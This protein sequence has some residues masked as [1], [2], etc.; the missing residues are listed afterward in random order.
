MLGLKDQGVGKVTFVPYAG[1]S[2]GN[3]RYVDMARVRFKEM[4][5]DLDAVTEGDPEERVARAESIVIGG[6]NTVELAQQLHKNRIMDAIRSR[7]KHGGVPYMGWSAGLGVACPTIGTTNDWMIPD[8]STL[9]IQGLDVFPVNIN[10]HYRDPVQITDELREALQAAYT[11]SP[12]LRDELENRG[13]TRIDRINEFMAKAPRQ[14]LGLREG[15]IVRVSGTKAMLEGT[16]GAK[17]FQPGKEPASYKPGDD[18]SF[19]IQAI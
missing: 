6:G 8:Q 9:E 18:L 11:I 19:L 15:G 7:V 10:P 13:E 2:I 4:G 17:H 12:E 16:A 3:E 5:F 14:V 1:V